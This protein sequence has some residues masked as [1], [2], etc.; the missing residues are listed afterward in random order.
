MRLTRKALKWLALATILYVAGLLLIYW[1]IGGT[2]LRI[3]GFVAIVFTV[4][5]TVW[6]EHGS[7][8]VVGIGTICR[9]EK[10]SMASD[11]CKGW[12]SFA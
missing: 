9:V 6:M 7:F 3:T 11:S 10:M 5:L 1:V 12:A 4:G 8:R 2:D